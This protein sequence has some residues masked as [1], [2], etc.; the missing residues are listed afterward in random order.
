VIWLA[1]SVAVDFVF[2]QF[3]K[4]GQRQGYHAPTVVSTNYVIVGT[5][6]ALY[7]IATDRFVVPQA[8]LITGLVT[9]CVFVSSMVLMTTTL[10]RAPAGAV[11]TVFRMSIAV[12]VVL[13]VLIWNEPVAPGQLLGIALA[14]IALGMM[15]SGSDADRHVTGLKMAGLLLA[16]FLLQGTSHSCLRSVHYNGLD[17]AFVQVLMVTGTTAGTLGWAAIAWSRQRPL[18]GELQLGAFI[19]FY[20]AL[21]L[22]VIMVALS[23]L[24]GTLFFPVVGCSVVVLDNLAAHFFWR[25]RLNRTSVAGVVVATLAIFLAV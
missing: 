11:F 18:R 19:G 9:G 6:L 25:E 2:V 10:E 21:A 13:G 15:T 12:P 5:S 17:D 22:C 23:L 20:N 3:F 14:L 8:A 16:I 4:W 24:P 7:L 1:V